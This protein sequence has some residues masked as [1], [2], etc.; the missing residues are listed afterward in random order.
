MQVSW[1]LLD[2]LLGQQPRGMALAFCNKVSGEVALK[3]LLVLKGVVQLAVGHAAAL[4]PAV[5]HL[6]HS[7]Q[8]PLALLAWDG[9][10]V[11]EVPVQICHLHP[12]KQHTILEC[13]RAEDSLSHSNCLHTATGTTLC[14][15]LCYLLLVATIWLLHAPCHLL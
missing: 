13:S 14:A 1:S 3:E 6:L 8:V 4:K 11:N 7:M 12:S 15:K 9:D 5:K 10:V 2:A